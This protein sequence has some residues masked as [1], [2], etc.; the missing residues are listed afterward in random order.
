MAT[1]RQQDVEREQVL[2]EMLEQF[3]PVAY[4]FVHEIR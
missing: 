2:Q 4:H 3:R 1:Q